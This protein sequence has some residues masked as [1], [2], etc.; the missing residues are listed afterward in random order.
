MIFWAIFTPL[1]ALALQGLRRSIAWFIAF[2][3]ELMVL[4]L[5]DPRLSQSSAAHPT[6]F[7]STFF[8]LNVM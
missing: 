8:V 3:A 6:A 2:F 4:A 1:A 5:L 7:V